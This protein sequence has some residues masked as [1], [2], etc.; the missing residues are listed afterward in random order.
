M[1]GI[2]ISTFERYQS[3]AHFTEQQIKRHWATPP[4]IFFSGLTRT[5]SD[6]QDR[7]LSFTSDPR[8]WMSVTLEA[9]EQ[10]RHRGFTHAYLIL[11]DH[12]PMGPCHDS[13]LNEVLPALAVQLNAAYIGLLGY[14]QHRQAHGTI[15]KKEMRFLERCSSRYQWKFSLHP[16]LWNL[17]ALQSLLEQRRKIYHGLERTAWN[18]ERHRDQPGDP[19]LEPFSERCFR[20]SGKH[21]LK[22]FGKMKLQIVT[23]AMERFVLDVMLYVVKKRGGMARRQQLEKKLLWRYGH[24]LGPYPLFWSG[25]M[26]KGKPHEG[27]EQ[28]LH[29]SGDQKLKEQWSILKNYFES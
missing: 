14:G 17:E 3:I 8:D 2:L 19:L 29:H 24:Y 21:F 12:P 13:F 23:E 6:S 9:V 22:Q 5:F 18:F 25:L 11:D 27:W 20:I 15:L 16:G 4:P 28:W 7:Y 10:M 26:Q 1:I